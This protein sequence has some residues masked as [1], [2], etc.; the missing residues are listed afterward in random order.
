[1]DELIIG[2]KEV[3]TM[4]DMRRATAT[5]PDCMPLRDY[6][7]RAGLQVTLIETDKGKVLEVA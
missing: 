3:K 2:T 5:V 4:G 1:M 7:K 6:V